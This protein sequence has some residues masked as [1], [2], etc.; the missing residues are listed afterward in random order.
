MSV[1]RFVAVSNGLPVRL[2]RAPDGALISE[3]GAGGLVAALAPV[4]RDRGG[5]WV[6]WPGLERDDE[7]DCMLA[8]AGREAGYILKPVNIGADDADLYYNGFSNQVI[9]PLFHDLSPRCRF[10]PEAWEAYGRA[11]RSFAEVV[12]G[13]CSGVDFI[14]V[15][16]YHLMGVAEEL[17]RLGVTIPVGFFLHIPFPPLDMFLRLPWR[18]EVLRSLLAYDLVGFQTLRDRRHFLYCLKRL[19]PG[20]KRH[21]AGSVLKVSHEGGEVRI[22]SFPIGIDYKA[23]D[24]RARELDVKEGAERLRGRLGARLMILGVDRLDYTKGIPEKLEAYRRALQKYPELREETVLVQIAVPS[25]QEAQGYREF[26]AEIE[27]L[28]SEINGQFARPGWE[29]IRYI[30]R[31]HDH[32]ELLQHYRAADIAVVT[33]IKDGMNLVAKEYC[34]A[35]VEEYGVLILSEFAGASSQMHRW[36]LTVNP[37][38]QDGIANAIHNAITMTAGDRR[39]RMRHLRKGVRT[40]DIYHWVDGFLRAATQKTLTDFPTWEDYVPAIECEPTLG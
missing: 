35:Q 39:N 5:L 37:H 20:V 8:E 31:N 10:S 6:G 4:L 21:G 40:Y 17:R 23:I 14:W 36:A 29:P 9:W 28:V 3:P 38:D 15:H 22:G 24:S 1:P 33:P 30:A 27:Q 16:D 32:V 26:T 7:V 13:C 34:A 25:R 18:A 11:N 2:S 12:A 19:M